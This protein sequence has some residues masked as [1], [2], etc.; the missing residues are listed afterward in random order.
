MKKCIKSS[1]SRTRIPGLT[2]N[3]GRGL[4][5]WYFK[6]LY[7]VISNSTLWM[8]DTIIFGTLGRIFQT[9]FIFP[10]LIFKNAV[11]WVHMPESTVQWFKRVTCVHE[12]ILHTCL[13]K[14]L[15]IIC[16]LL[17]DSKI[18]H[19]IPLLLVK[20]KQC[21]CISLLKIYT[22]LDV[23]KFMQNWVH[24]KKLWCYYHNQYMYMHV[25]IFNN[26]KYVSFK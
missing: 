22:K 12:E 18:L 16:I 6:L 25:V 10:E 1:L 26:Y 5:Y 20:R 3:T 24:F 17:M 4:R 9:Q 8:I 13:K 2:P 21:H 14:T 19:T 15:K 11:I 7:A 23:S